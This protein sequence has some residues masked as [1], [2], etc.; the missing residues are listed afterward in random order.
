VIHNLADPRG[1]VN[2]GSLPHPRRRRSTRDTAG[3]GRSGGNGWYLSRCREIFCAIDSQRC[4][5]V[6][7]ELLKGEAVRFRPQQPGDAL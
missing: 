7:C 5:R 3:A 2:V 1:E 4:S 6:A